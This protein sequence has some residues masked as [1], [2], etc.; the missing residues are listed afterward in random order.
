MRSA[1]EK[2][3]FK[4]KLERRTMEFSV[5][6]FKALDSLPKRVSAQV[7]AA[8]LGRSAS[9]IGAN[10]REANRAESANDFSHKISIVLKECSETLYWIEIE[11]KLYDDSDGFVGFAGECEELLRLFQTI[12]RHVK[13]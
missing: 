13:K 12:R 1:E 7:V 10:Y 2:L 9:S 4:R 8:Q 5:S 3:E 11:Q 6:V